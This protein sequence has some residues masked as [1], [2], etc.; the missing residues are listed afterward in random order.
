MSEKKHGRRF[1]IRL[2]SYITA[3]TAVLF[4]WGATQTAKASEYEKRL[5]VSQQRTISSLSEYLSSVE[6][7]LRKMQYVNTRAMTSS[8]SVSLA[9]AAAGA[10]TCLSE[11]SSGET[12]LYNINKFLSQAS[13]YIQ[14]LNKK[15][16]SG[17]E[18]TDKDY[19]QITSLYEYSSVL[20]RQIGYIEE[21]MYAGDI[22][23]EDTVSSLSQLKD[24]GDLSLSYPD[25]ISD[26]EESFS[27]Y[28]TLIYDGPF[29]D[30]VMS[31]ESEMLKSEKEISESQAKTLASKYSGIEE[32]KLIKK[33]DEK[34]HLESY[35]F[36]CDGVTVAVT[37]KGG[38]LNYLLSDKYA[39]EE[40]ISKEEAVEKARQ[41]L[42]K[43]GYISMKDSYYWDNDG[44][45]TVNFAYTL[46]DV[47]CYG[48]LIKV[49]VSLETGEIVSA[50]AA[51]YLMNHRDRGSQSAE[52]SKDEAW[53]NVSRTL[54]ADSSRMAIIP[55]DDG[56][57]VYSYEFLCHD[58]EGSD[59]LVY[60]DA[61][62]GQEAEILLLLYGDGGVLTK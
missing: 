9:K 19:Q 27:D 40:K 23:F 35:I 26:A 18:L 6:T 36:Y 32:N 1:K 50:D 3:L 24:T 5:S 55:T 37:K 25:T 12:Q 51:D 52:I 11:L 4:I 14:S 16:S 45:C 22:R 42:E 20:S 61:E 43:C 31:K 47:I 56:N 15:V 38:Y 29:S 59:V 13:D 21:V 54:T 62:T 44:I 39:G 10:K 28:P 17:E 58:K 41:Y 48:D 7:D 2:A 57:E 30:N 53:A 49:S 34:G 60:I 33:E 8:L 46:G